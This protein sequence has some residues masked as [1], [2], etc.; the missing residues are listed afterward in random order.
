MHIKD[1]LSDGTVV[2]AGYG[3]GFVKEIASAYMEKGGE[4]FTIEPHLTE[5]Y[6]FHSLEKK[7]DKR[8]TAGELS[9]EATEAAAEKAA[10]EA[11][12]ETEPARKLS[13][14]EAFDVACKAFREM[15]TF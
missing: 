8:K 13:D 6:G 1:A 3:T 5:F 4:V 12:M 11:V 14:Q 10:E 2:P 9:G 15:I 7:R